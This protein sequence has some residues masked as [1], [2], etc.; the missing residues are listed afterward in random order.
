MSG[1]E[2]DDAEAIELDQVLDALGVAEL[3]LARHR[4]ERPLAE[5]ADR[6]QQKAPVGDDRGLLL[7]RQLA[8]QRL[9][10]GDLARQLGEIHLQ[11]A[12]HLVDSRERHV[13]LGEDA[14]DARFR[15][16]ERF[17]EVGVSDSCRAQLGLE[18]VDE[19]LG[20]AHRRDY[21]AIENSTALLTAYTAPSA[22]ITVAV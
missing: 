4:L 6:E 22:P 3:V 7:D 11:D 8:R 5:A 15:H 19:I 17:G 18:D 14:L 21:F 2:L 16:A 1:A 20:C 10:V 12:Q 13:G 9:R